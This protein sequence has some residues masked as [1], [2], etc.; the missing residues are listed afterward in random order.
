MAVRARA[1]A[2]YLQISQSLLLATLFSATLLVLVFALIFFLEELLA[3]REPS[4]TL[5]E[6]GQP[7]Q[8][9][10]GE[11]KRWHLFLSVC[12]RL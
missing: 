4:F 2:P 10:L 7:P 12:R 8:L 5:A 11:G 6:T 9:T 3:A 1:L